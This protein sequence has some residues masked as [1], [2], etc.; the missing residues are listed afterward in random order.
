MCEVCHSKRRS[1]ILVIDDDAL[2]GRAI[3]RMLAADYDVVVHVDARAAIEAVQAGERFD[4]I[5][6]DLMMDPLSGVDV[7]AAVQNHDPDLLERLGFVTAGAFTPATQ[8]FIETTDRP[9]LAKPFA[10]NDLLELARRL[11][12]RDAPRPER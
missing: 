2:V 11:S 5:L 9:I 12:L 1:R 3:A 4:A 6:C 8:A 7:H 10:R